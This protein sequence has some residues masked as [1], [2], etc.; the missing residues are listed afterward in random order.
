MWFLSLLLSCTSG[1]G[2]GERFVGLDYARIAIA[3]QG[4]VI[5][6]QGEWW[7]TFT[8][9]TAPGAE[10]DW[11]AAQVALSHAVELRED[12]PVDGQASQ[13][14]QQRM[15]VLWLRGTPPAGKGV[16]NAQIGPHLVPVRR[17][18]ESAWEE[19]AS[20]PCRPSVER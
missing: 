10:V 8:L 13:G 6:S 18:P 15:R 12:P 16:A 19:L 4:R 1:P 2:P 7:A 11:A 17:S 5:P 9:Q 3:C 20:E 14:W